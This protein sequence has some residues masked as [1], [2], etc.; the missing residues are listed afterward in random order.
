MLLMINQPNK[1]GHQHRISRQ[2][3]S[4]LGE[5][6][7]RI[8]E[9]GPTAGRARIGS[10]VLPRSLFRRLLSCRIILS[11]VARCKAI[12]IPSLLFFLPVIWVAELISS[13]NLKQVARVIS[14]A[15]IFMYLYFELLASDPQL[16]RQRVHDS[17]RRQIKAINALSD[18]GM[19]FWDYGN[20]FLLE[21]KRCGADVSARDDPTGL[22]FR[23][24]SYVQ[25]I[26]R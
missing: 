26:M 23:Y 15:F 17:L 14:R 5:T 22:K 10:N 21:A 18:C 11:R 2:R 12:L 3:C 1:S 16:F 4:R 7:R 25:D 6:G 20:A 9:D 8:R 13:I 19:F 24:P